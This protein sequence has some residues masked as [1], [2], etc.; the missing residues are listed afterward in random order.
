MLGEINR[1]YDFDQRCQL[2][3]DMLILKLKEGTQP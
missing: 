1:D 2:M 3:I